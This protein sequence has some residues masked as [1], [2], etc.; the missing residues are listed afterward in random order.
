MKHVNLSYTQAHTHTNIC[1]T[2][3]KTKE[4]LTINAATSCHG[5]GKIVEQKAAQEATSFRPSTCGSL[6][7]A[8]RR[9]SRQTFVQTSAEFQSCIHRPI[10]FLL[11]NLDR[12]FIQS[13]LVSNL[14]HKARVPYAQDNWRA[15][16]RNPNDGST[17][18]TVHDFE[19]FLQQIFTSGV[20]KSRLWAFK[21]LERTA[22]LFGKGFVVHKLRQSE[23]SFSYSEMGVQTQPIGSI[24]LVKLCSL[25]ITMVLI[26]IPNSNSLLRNYQLAMLWF[27]WRSP[28]C[29]S[30]LGD[31]WSSSTSSLG[32]WMQSHPHFYCYFAQ[33]Q[34]CVSYTVI[35]NKTKS[36]VF[37][38]SI[39]D[40]VTN[41]RLR[42]PVA[43]SSSPRRVTQQAVCSQISWPWWTTLRRDK[44]GIQRNWNW[45]RHV[46]ANSIKGCASSDISSNLYKHRCRLLRWEFV[47]LQTHQSHQDMLFQTYVH[48][49]TSTWT[50]VRTPRCPVVVGKNSCG[51][52][53]APCILFSKCPLLRFVETYVILIAKFS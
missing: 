22:L 25:L 51:L 53:G 3:T 7:R 48:V 35:Q 8:W 21:L 46:F 49:L 18:S 43:A 6:Q 52:V 32:C 5:F 17:V 27:V 39:L 1:L 38:N 20:F 23:A 44:S 33:N 30:W 40:P 31:D 41:S 42:R 4:L 29:P 47:A 9:S 45:W 34:C 12:M 37:F 36:Q 10:Y 13:R 19:V 16:V 28:L 11:P 24:F 14:W 50:L 15:F 26:W 2:I